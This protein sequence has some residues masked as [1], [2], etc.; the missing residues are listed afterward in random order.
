MDGV[1][2]LGLIEGSSSAVIGLGI[3]T[4]LCVDGDDE[5]SGMLQSVG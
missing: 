4:C 2:E 5:I 3:D 1:E